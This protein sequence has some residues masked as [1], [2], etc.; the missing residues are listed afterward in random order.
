VNYFGP[1]SEEG[2]KMVRR[3]LEDGSSMARRWLEDGSKIYGIPLKGYVLSSFII[4][5]Q[6]SSIALFTSSKFLRDE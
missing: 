5:P 3:W 4:K 1:V 6:L 2:S